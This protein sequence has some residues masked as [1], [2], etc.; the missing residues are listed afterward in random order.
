VQPL[1]ELTNG[2]TP[3]RFIHGQQMLGSHLLTTADQERRGLPLRWLATW[4]GMSNTR[5]HNFGIYGP[6][7]AGEM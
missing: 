7:R 5:T 6:D 1:I 2:T 4:T 3:V